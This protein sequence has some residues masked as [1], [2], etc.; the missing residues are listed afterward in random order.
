MTDYG[1]LSRNTEKVVNTLVENKIPFRHSPPE[2][3]TD[4][5]VIH[6]YTR[7]VSQMEKIFEECC[8]KNLLTATDGLLF[9]CPFAA[10]AHRLKSIPRD[11]NNSVPLKSGPS[12]IARY[13]SEISHLPACN[14]CKG[15]SYGAPEI[16]PAIQTKIPLK[17]K[18]FS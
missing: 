3:W 18:A 16:E 5:G 4:S 13:T 6:D 14:F 7:S 10:N 11:E 15:R 12:E 9:R 17:Y 8:G 1:N 2:N